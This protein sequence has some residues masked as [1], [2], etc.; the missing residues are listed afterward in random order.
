MESMNIMNKNIILNVL[1]TYAIDKNEKPIITL[2][3][4]IIQNGNIEEFKDIFFKFI[5][6]TQ[7]YGYIEYLNEKLKYEFIDF[8]SFRSS[9]YKGIS[10]EYYNRGQL[11][12]LNEMQK[13]PK[14]FVSAPT[15]FGKTSLIMDLIL[16][17]RSLF[18]NVLMILPT[19]SLIEELFLK[20][21]KANNE[22]NLDYH[23]S[24]QPKFYKNKNNILLLTPERYLILVE[25]IKTDDFDL[26]I[27]DETYKIVDYNNNNKNITISD[28][29][30]RRSYRFRKVAD[31]L[32]SSDSKVLY[33]SPY[34]YKMKKSMMKF[35]QKYSITNL[36][37]K[38][39]YVSHEIIRLEYSSDFETVFG[40]RGYVKDSSI[41]ERTALILNA[42]GNDKSIVYVGNYASAYNIVDLLPER[43]DCLE[44]RYL[45][46]LEHM[47]ENYTI[48]GTPTWKVVVGLQKRV[49]IYISPLPRY[50][51]KEIVNLYELGVLRTLI[52]TTAFTEGINTD[53]EHLVI[54]SLVNGPTTKKLTELDLLNTIGRA[55]RF[56]QQSIGKVY[57][58]TDSIYER[59]LE[60]R[61]HDE[62]ELFNENYKEHD[63]YIR[64]DY[65]IDMIQNDYLNEFEIKKK[66]R[67]DSNIKE[68][69][70]TKKDMDISLNVSNAWKLELYKKFSTIE[71]EKIEEIKTNVEYLLSDDGNRLKGIEYIF[72]FIYTTIR[73]MDIP[74][75]QKPYEI[76]PFDREGG[77]TWGRLYGLYSSYTTKVMIHKNMDYIIKKVNT[78]RKEV[79]YEKSYKSFK[80]IMDFR[81]IGWICRYLKDD[82]T[83]QYDRFYTEAFK[84]ISSI[85]QYKIPY[86]I[87]FFVSIF[88]LFL[89]KNEIYTDFIKKIDLNNIV[90]IFENNNSKDEYSLLIDFGIS[91]DILLKFSERDITLSQLKNIDEFDFLDDY[92]KVMIKDILIYL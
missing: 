27:M 46:F 39:D 20:F 47:K 66:V 65:E 17:D 85:I 89:T 50:V 48:I 68:L 69:N 92:E 86:Y 11:S 88:K 57:C 43:C 30:N 18:N 79:G 49:G 60:V 7:F 51:K 34:T 56:A 82:F 80:A 78:L 37:R 54:T 90:S 41:K 28:F 32:G 75:P 2:I 16:E 52:V 72:R 36:V 64:N 21:N 3:N 61:N 40:K 6:A 23:V 4:K 55:G 35:L 1:N 8:D 76:K 59:V 12:L 45:Q 81:G 25:E 62:I 44:K 29:V 13:N 83:P 31:M 22:Y 19:N 67:L 74:F 63:G 33:L 42:L 77:F 5:S 87:S 38:I 73:S 84:F 14:V 9:S 26:I 71:I 70:L 58:I 53:A 10:I 91:N 24:T 15:S